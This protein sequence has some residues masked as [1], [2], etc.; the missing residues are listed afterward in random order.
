MDVEL[1]API[2]NRFVTFYLFSSQDKK[3]VDSCMTFLE[4]DGIYSFTYHQTGTYAIQCSTSEYEDQF[5]AG[6][7]SIDDATPVEIQSL[8]QTTAN[9][10]FALKRATA[11]SK[12]AISGMV[13]ESETN[14]PLEL[15]E[16]IAESKSEPCVLWSTFSM[17]DSGSF[18]PFPAG[19]FRLDDLPEDSYTVWAVDF[20]GGHATEY[21]RD[22]EFER[23]AM[24]VTVVNAQITEGIDF[25]LSQAGKISGK[26][27]NESGEPVDSIFVLAVYNKDTQI[28]EYLVDQFINGYLYY[29][30]TDENGQFNIVGLPAGKYAV[31]T[32]SYQTQPG[33]FIDHPYT[34]PVTIANG[35]HVEDIDF[36]LYR[37]GAIIGKILDA[38]LCPI[39]GEIDAYVFNSQ[40][41]NFEF[42]TEFNVSGSEYRISGLDTGEYSVFFDL[43]TQ[44]APYVSQFYDGHTAFNL[45]GAKN[46]PVVRGEETKNID[47]TISLGGTINGHLYLP[48]GLVT[49]ADTLKKTLIILYD[50]SSAEYVM[51]K[52]TTFCGGYEIKGIP[53]GMYKLCAF[54]TTT[55]GAVSYYGGGE[56]FHDAKSKTIEMRPNE[57]YIADMTMFHANARINGRTVKDSDFSPL[58][59]VYILAYDESGHAVSFGVSG[60]QLE[61]DRFLGDGNYSIHSLRPGSYFLRSWFIFSLHPFF[62]TYLDA[63]YNQECYDEW[64]QD[65]R[66]EPHVVPNSFAYYKMYFAPPFFCAVHPN[67]A[68]LTIPD[69]NSVAE[70]IVFE[71]D[72]IENAQ[73]TPEK[74]QIVSDF[75]LYQNI[76]NPFNPDTE[77]RYDLGDGS[78]ITLSIYNIMGEKITDLVDTYQVKGTYSVVWSG[79]DVLQNKVSSGVYFCILQCGLH[80]QI[81]KM[82]LID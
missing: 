43:S 9:I 23:D 3:L 2:Q 74:A 69:P 40:T 60:V 62:T 81:K 61:N 49:G 31:Q 16:I 52:S 56:T 45:T 7:I 35:S 79:Q 32:Y 71:L 44:T 73:L 75:V 65:V 42:F 55:D 46:I 77:I 12:G 36:I 19:S 14:Q 6:Q 25:T 28:P 24:P 66:I 47:V 63:H 59:F 5:Y 54:A 15:V 70:D 67:A 20:F 30:Q 8:S 21:F 53:A 41:G 39:N 26:I 82:A 18:Q 33:E 13:Y 22:A 27:I 58:N 10:D 29:G 76:P 64:Y 4:A 72:P 80:R 11:I 34:A 1:N 68:K 17:F 51:D 48:N 50:V 57:I 78:H 38:I 37:A